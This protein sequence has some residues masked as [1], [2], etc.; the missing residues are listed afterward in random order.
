MDALTWLEGECRPG[1]R[2]GFPSR[3][4]SHADAGREH[5]GKPGSEGGVGGRGPAQRICD[6]A[7]G[8]EVSACFRSAHPHSYHVGDHQK[9]G[10]SKRM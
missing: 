7:R 6:L 5:G 8:V 1:Y 4:S 9:P 10:T 3:E 2:A